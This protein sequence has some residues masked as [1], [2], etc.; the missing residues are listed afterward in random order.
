MRLAG[1]LLAVLCALASAGTAAG[2][3]S[4][5]FGIQDDAWLSFGPGTLAERVDKLD[6][7]GVD[8]VRVTLEWHQI[9]PEPGEFDWSRPD[10]LLQALRAR[11]ISPLV[12]I[13][14][15]PRWANGAPTPNWA[16]LRPA[17][18]QRFAHAA[19]E[20]YPFVRSWLIWNEPNQRRWL[21]PTSPKAYVARILNPAYRGI[22]SASPGAK[23]AGGTTAPRGSTGGLSPVQFIRG[24]DA[25]HARLDV[26]AHHP[27]PLSPADT[28]FTGGCGHCETITMSTL[29]RLLREVGNAFPHARVWLTEYAYQTNPPDRTL[30]VSPVQQARYIAEAALRVRQAPK[31]DL[32][33]H[34]LYRDEPEL[35]R[36]QSGLETAR[37]RA[38]P[39]MRATMLPLAQVSR[40]DTMTRVWGQVRPGKGRQRYV[41][42]RFSGGGWRAVGGAQTTSPRGYLERTVLAGRG[43]KLRLWYPNERV[44]GITLLVR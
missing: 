3:A 42:Q 26:Y 21:R 4:V 39:G 19:A 37:G 36:W 24:M 32:L 10:A 2:S 22:K 40:R 6:R 5:R 43:T 17:D 1:C 14:G 33:V 35:G 23:V 8:V 44:A 7:L 20:R 38:K 15:A 41:L 34:Y 16:P 29:E 9:E 27:Y 28:P 13:W 18:V 31:V 11:G 12:T 25:A 30:G